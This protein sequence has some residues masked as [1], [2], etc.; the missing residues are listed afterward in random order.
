MRNLL[1]MIIISLILIGCGKEPPEPQEPVI[2]VKNNYILPPDSLMEHLSVTKPI[3]KIKYITLTPIE[4]EKELTI[5]SINLMA[6]VGVLNYRM[7]LLQKW[8]KK[9]LNMIK[10]MESES[11]D[12]KET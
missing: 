3:S 12:G 10:N 8:K 7:M 5:L 11:K 1:L 4:R 2:R 6:D 9:H